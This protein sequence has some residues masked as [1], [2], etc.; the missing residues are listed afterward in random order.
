MVKTRVKVIND[1]NQFKLYLDDYIHLTFIQSE[2]LGFQSW[3]KGT[4]WFCI[5]FVFHGKPKILCEY[6]S[7]ELWKLILKELDNYKF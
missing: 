6:S 7:I 2:F 3:V 4:E 1:G 5:E